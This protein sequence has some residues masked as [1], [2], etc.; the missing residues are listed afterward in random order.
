[1]I[2]QTKYFG[3]IDLSE[4]KVI[5]FENGI[6]GFESLK[7]FTLLYDSEKEKKPNISWLQSLDEQNIALPVINPFLVMEDYNP[8]VEDEILRPLGEITNE[9][10]AILLVATIPSDVKQ[11]TAN[12]KAPIIVN[13]DTNKG[14][15]IIVENADYPIRYNVYDVIQKSDEQKGDE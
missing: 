1:M 11:M 12:L 3:E 10:V 8:I 14:C 4:D 13:V 6:M 2:V 7:R 9:N 15:Q 5:T